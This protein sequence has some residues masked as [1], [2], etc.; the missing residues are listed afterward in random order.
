M[1]A[2]IFFFVQNFHYKKND[3]Y[4]CTANERLGSDGGRTK[5]GRKSD[6]SRTKVRR[7]R[8]DERDD[9]FC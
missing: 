4:L 9:D 2:G 5:V 8:D 7:G 1:M 3:Y 6:K